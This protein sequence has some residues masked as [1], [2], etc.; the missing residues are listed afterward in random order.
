MEVKVILVEPQLGENIGAVARVMSN[1]GFTD[2][3]IVNPRDGWPNEKAV[4]MA[5]HGA[6]VVENA[7]IYPDFKS[8]IAD[9]HYVIATT[10][11]DRYMEKSVLT[12]KTLPKLSGNVGMVFGRERSGLTNEEIS[13]CDAIVAITTSEINP[14]LNIAQAVAICCY[15]LSTLKKPEIAEPEQALRG[16]LNVFVDFLENELEVSGFFK[17]PEIAPT[18]KRNIRNY[19]TRSNMTEQDLKTMWG[20]IKSLINGKAKNTSFGRDI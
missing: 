10:A 20:M 1:F 7:V 12:P 8:A 13:Y 5:A 19:F 17:N 3:R 18:M 4:A 15:E 6:F 16:D 9:M 2:L 14:S 11:Q